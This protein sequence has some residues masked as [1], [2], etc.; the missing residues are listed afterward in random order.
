VADNVVV[1]AVITAETFSGAEGAATAVTASELSEALDCP[2]EF[3]AFT[4]YE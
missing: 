3:T 4:E 1:P 2:V